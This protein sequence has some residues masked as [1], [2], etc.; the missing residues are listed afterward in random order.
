MDQENGS[1]E[2][3]QKPAR[4]INSTSKNHTTCLPKHEGTRQPKKKNTEI[5]TPTQHAPEH[6]SSPNTSPGTKMGRPPNLRDHKPHAK[7][8][9]TLHPQLISTTLLLHLLC[10]RRQGVH[11]DFLDQAEP[12]AHWRGGIRSCAQFCFY[13]SGSDAGGGLVAVRLESP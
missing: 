8:L 12:V 6:P 4:L 9:P 11:L 5:I 2:A 10:L 3:S 7:R 1:S 13:V